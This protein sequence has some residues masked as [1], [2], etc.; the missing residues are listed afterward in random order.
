MT[1]THYQHPQKILVPVTEAL[2][3]WGQD[4]AIYE[5][6]LDGEFAVRAVPGGILAGEFFPKRAAFIAFDVLEYNGNDVTK[7]PLSQRQGLRDYL[8]EKNLMHSVPTFYN[9]RQ[10]LEFV[11]ARGG[12]GVCRKELDATYFTPM[13]AAKRGGIWVCRVSSVGS[14]QAVSIVDAETGQDRGRV[15]LAGGKVEKVKVGSIIRV[16]G[17]NLTAA[18]KIRQPQPAREWLVAY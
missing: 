1:T 6:K 4:G 9:G 14:S 17:M 8:C 16:E 10:A 5:E 12:E 18:G 13:L 3:S 15:M 7:L 2:A 11:L